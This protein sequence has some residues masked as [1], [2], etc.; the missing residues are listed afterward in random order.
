MDIK[1]TRLVFIVG[2]VVSCAVWVG[3]LG[4]QLSAG[5]GKTIIAQ[6]STTPDSVPTFQ[7]DPF[8]PKPLPHNWQMGDASGVF[9]DSKDHIWVADRPGISTLRRKEPHWILLRETAAY[10]RHRS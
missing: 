8:W 1:S 10:L 5:D 4:A 2:A 7:V 9:A 6:K 3:I